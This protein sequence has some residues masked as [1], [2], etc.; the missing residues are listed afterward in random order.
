LIVVNLWDY[1][2]GSARNYAD[3]DG[4]VDVILIEGTLDEIR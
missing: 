3:M 2:F 4:L 1:Y